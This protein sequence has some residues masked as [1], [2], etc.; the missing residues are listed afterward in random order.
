MLSITRKCDVDKIKSGRGS[1][2]EEPYSYTWYVQHENTPC[3]VGGEKF[4][5]VCEVYAD[6][7]ELQ[8]IITNFKNLPICTDKRVNVWRGEL[9]QFI[10]ENL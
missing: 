8:H 10:Y 3:L 4:T 1:Y 6:G 7:H 9:A 5:D 2:D